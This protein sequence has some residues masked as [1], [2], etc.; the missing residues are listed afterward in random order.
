M[1]NSV[2]ILL[3]VFVFFSCEKDD[4]SNDLAN[5]SGVDDIA[6]QANFGQS[7]TAD[8]IGRIVDDN[9]VRLGGVQITI[10]NQ[11]VFTDNQGVFVINNVAV[12]ENFAYVKAS[13]E[14]YIDGSRAIMP[15]QG[16][17]NDIQITLLEKNIVGSVTSGASSSVNL[18]NGAK[19]SFQG[20]FIDGSGNPYNGSV[21]VSIHYLRPNS[22]ETFNQMPGMLFAQDAANEARMLE[23]YGMLAVNLF[24]ASGEHL[25]IDPNSLATLE[26]PVDSSTP[27]APDSIPLW[28]FDESTGYWKE[29]GQATRVDNKYIGEVS[30]FTWWNCD[31]PLDR[32]YLCFNVSSVGPLNDFYVELIRDTNDQM[33]FSGYTNSN[34]N[35]CGIIPANETMTIKVYSNCLSTVLHEETIGPFSSYTTINVIVPDVTD[36]EQTNLSASV[37]TCTASP[38]HNGY[39]VLFDEQHINDINKHILIPITNGVLDYNFSYCVGHTYNIMFYDTIGGNVSDIIAIALQPDTTDLGNVL[40][41]TQVSS[42]YEGNLSFTNDQEISYFGFYG[43][44]KV[45]GNIWFNENWGDDYSYDIT[46][47][48]PLN[49]LKEVT[50]QVWMYDM[51]A[52]T[53]FNGFENLEIVGGDLFIEVGVMESF[54]GLNNLQRAGNLYIDGLPIVDLQ[55]LESLMEVDNLDVILNIQL[56]S[57]NGLNSLT[58]INENL[59]IIGNQELLNLN[60]LNN[61]TN[62]GGNLSVVHGNFTSLSGIESLNNVGGSVQIGFWEYTPGATEDAPNPNLT[63]FCALQ[64]LFTN[65]TYGNVFIEN[66]AYNPTV[67]DIIDGNCSQ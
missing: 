4:F 66:N 35:E 64:N 28:Y 63:D 20:D 21:D 24:G 29:Q 55:G 17:P 13:K 51:G 65:G 60:G 11:T 36:M 50:G 15:S 30:H 18:T 53:N 32:E 1:K 57:L 12:Y 44:E 7:I 61:I 46:S 58:T 47:L 26:F 37:R 52:L 5:N 33:I 23:T 42:V 16:V 2:L 54:Q 59:A 56:E 25:N 19:V 67:Q 8:F 22:E 39:A 41:C 48:Q 34:G 14:G 9:G 38:V 62:V 10:D 45:I 40:T 6:F 27:N 43:Y 49:T 3:F 31:V